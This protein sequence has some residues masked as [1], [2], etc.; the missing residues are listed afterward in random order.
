MSVFECKLKYT[1]ND[2]RIQF[3][4]KSI[5]LHLYLYLI[6]YLDGLDLDRRS[7]Y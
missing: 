1:K 4:T 6:I 7:Y 5:Y 3:Y 2:I